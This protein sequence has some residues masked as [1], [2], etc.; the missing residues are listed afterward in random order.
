MVF[1][2]LFS[3]RSAASAQKPARRSISPQSLSR[4]RV[5]RSL[6]Y[7]SAACPLPRGEQEVRDWVV[8][9]GNEESTDAI[10]SAVQAASQDKSHRV[11]SRVLVSSVNPGG[12]WSA[13]S[14]CS[15]VDEPQLSGPSAL[16]EYGE[17]LMMASYLRCS[18]SKLPPDGYSRFSSISELGL[19]EPAEP[20]PSPASTSSLSSA[21]SLE[22]VESCEVAEAVECKLARPATVYCPLPH[23]KTDPETS[24]SLYD[25]EI[26]SDAHE[27]KVKSFRLSEP[28]ESESSDDES[29]YGDD[30][31]EDDYDDYDFDDC[32]FA[33]E[34]P[35]GYTRLHQP[36]LRDG[37]KLPIRVV[38]CASTPDP[39]T[40]YPVQ[41]AQFADFGEVSD[42]ENDDYWAT[43]ATNSTYRFQTADL[44]DVSDLDEDDLDFMDVDA[45]ADGYTRRNHFDRLPGR[46]ANE[47]TTLVRLEGPQPGQPKALG[48]YCVGTV[49]PRSERGRDLMAT[50]NG[51]YSLA[52]DVP[53]ARTRRAVAGNLSLI[54]HLVAGTVPRPDFDL[55]ARDARRAWPEVV[56]ALICI[57]WGEHALA[58]EIW[59]LLEEALFRRKKLQ[60]SNSNSNNKSFADRCRALPSPLRTCTSAQDQ[61]QDQD[62]D[63]E[64]IEYS[65]ADCA[66]IDDDDDDDEMFDITDFI[67]PMRNPKIMR[68]RG[69]AGQLPQ[70]HGDIDAEEPE[71][72]EAARAFRGKVTATTATSPESGEPAGTKLKEVVDADSL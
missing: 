59:L 16:P 48:T 4:R 68:L 14:S 58:V 9:G 1:G 47:C 69:G 21:A 49:N 34:A 56:D 71:G 43:G 11:I 66:I 33:E 23:T 54:H 3:R 46:A 29:T 44:D 40:P 62:Q 70:G 50:I 57:S 12:P 8:S 26:I 39:S 30:E 6:P 2:W 52:P 7:T 13:R 51:A 55:R 17:S 65:S 53:I 67:K 63:Q 15:S 18:T 20:S 25:P 61:D 28:F 36:I 5:D 10:K 42:M 72:D 31:E 35:A 64:H 41:E 19:R 45:D 22:L 32:S 37:K 24:D 60:L 27:L 38:S